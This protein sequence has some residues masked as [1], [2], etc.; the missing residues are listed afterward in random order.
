MGENTYLLFL[1]IEVINDDTNEEIKRKERSKNDEKYKVEIHVDVSL[2][3][4]LLVH[5]YLQNK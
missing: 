1:F 5:L 2:S 4:R 3:D